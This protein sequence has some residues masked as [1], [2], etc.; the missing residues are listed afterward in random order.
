MSWNLGP[1]VHMS[2]QPRPHKKLTRS[3]AA[4]DSGQDCISEGGKRAKDLPS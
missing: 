1:R 3:Y 2:A 4:H